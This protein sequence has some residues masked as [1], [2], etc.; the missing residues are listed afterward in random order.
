MKTGSLLPLDQMREAMRVMPLVEI[1]INREVKY[2]TPRPAVPLEK[3]QLLPES[4]RDRSK[5]D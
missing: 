2:D 1:P 4:L 5:A 3:L